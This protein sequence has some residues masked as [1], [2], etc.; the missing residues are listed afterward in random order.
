MSVWR[1]RLWQHCGPQHHCNVVAS[2][3][4][5]HHA[6]EEVLAGY[7]VCIEDADELA[8]RDGRPLHA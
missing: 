3:K 1:F 8:A 4:H 5:R 6:Q 7:L 2:V